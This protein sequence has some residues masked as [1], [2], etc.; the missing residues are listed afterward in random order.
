ML[1]YCGMCVISA[2]ELAHCRVRFIK[3]SIRSGSKCLAHHPRI[4]YRPAPESSIPRFP[5]RREMDFVSCESTS[6]I[7]VVVAI[8]RVFTTRDSMG[9]YFKAERHR[10]A[11]PA[12][13]W[14]PSLLSRRRARS[15]A[16]TGV[17]WIGL[18]GISGF[19]LGH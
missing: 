7:V 11:T 14:H 6:P 12:C 8:K 15:A 4:G 16:R 2:M 1:H 3:D 13:F 17:S 9:S 5:S 18:F 10:S 19:I